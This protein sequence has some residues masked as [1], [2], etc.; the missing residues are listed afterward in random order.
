MAILCLI[1]R[2]NRMNRHAFSTINAGLHGCTLS[3]IVPVLMAIDTHSHW[4]A[5]AASSAGVPACFLAGYIEDLRKLRRAPQTS[6]TPDETESSKTPMFVQTAYQIVTVTGI[7]SLREIVVLSGSIVGNLQSAFQNKSIREWTKRKVIRPIA[8][9]ARASRFSS[10]SPLSTE[11]KQAL[12]ESP[13]RFVTMKKA[14]A[15]KIPR[16]TS[17]CDVLK[18]PIIPWTGA[19]VAAAQNA[20]LHWSLQVAMGAL[21]VAAGVVTFGQELKVW[22]QQDKFKNIGLLMFAENHLNSATANFI[23]GQNLKGWQMA[24]YALTCVSLYLYERNGGAVQ[25]AQRVRDYIKNREIPPL[26]PIL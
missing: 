8:R 18:N 12:Q 16:F 14:V 22:L 6:G 7:S 26:A 17:M 19:Y 23:T 13:R 1:L 20:N 21:F 24:V 10:V 3:M 2:Y 15:A 5:L 11:D 4:W 9:I 25:T